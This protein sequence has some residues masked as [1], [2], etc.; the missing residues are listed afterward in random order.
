MRSRNSLN[1][2]IMQFTRSFFKYGSIIIGLL[3]LSCQGGK[4]GSDIDAT[5]K[6]IHEKI[7]TVDTHADTPSELDHIDLRGGTIL[8]ER[9]GKVD[10]TRMKEGGLDA[11]FFAVY[12]SPGPLNDSAYK[13]AKDKAMTMFHETHSVLEKNSDLAELA[14][15]AEDAKKLEA[16]GK[17]AIYIGIENGYAIGRD[18]SLL[19]TYYDL[20]TRYITL[21]H[22]RN[23][24]ICDSSTDDP[25]HFGLSDFG[26][27]VVEEMN[28][29]GIMVDVSHISDDSFFDVIDHSAVP[30]IASHSCARALYDHPRNMSNEMLLKLKES[31]GVI[32]V[33]LVSDFVKK[34]ENEEVMQIEFATLQEKFGDPDLLSQDSL[35]LYRNERAGLRERYPRQYATVSDLVDHIDHVVDLIGI[36]HVGIGSD[37]DG[38]GGLADCNDVSEMGNITRE[39][40]SRGYTEKEIAKI[41]G[42][43]LMRVFMAV[44]EYA[45][46]SE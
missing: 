29:L 22:S 26:K 25:L 43:N 2:Y 1:R 21:C 6:K 5:A 30:V 38:G 28:R 9:A 33:T 41:W 17:R 14:L 18:L 10:F 37:F 3:I 11:I 24:D 23:N 4:D 42:G 13:V 39:L 34:R 27:K 8:D 36:D 20:G 35:E 31:N 46:N 32:Q 19:N 12:V 45:G 15:Q 16:I 40:I 7:L 44:E